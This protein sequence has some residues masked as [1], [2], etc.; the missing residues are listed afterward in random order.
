MSRSKAW[1][2]RYVERQRVEYAKV[3]KPDVPRCTRQFNNFARDAVYL[4]CRHV[5]CCFYFA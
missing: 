1:C 2:V 5:S 4:L 3:R